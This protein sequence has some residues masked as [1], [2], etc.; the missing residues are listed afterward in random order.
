MLNE[1][2]NEYVLELKQ[3]FINVKFEYEMDQFNSFQMAASLN[4]R[5]L[6]LC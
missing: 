5:Q 6:I 2:T 3:N 1:T 4:N